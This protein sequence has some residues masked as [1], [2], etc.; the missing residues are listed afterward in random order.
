MV[1]PEPAADGEAQPDVVCLPFAE[2][3]PE[4]L[5]RIRPDIVFSS[6][7]GPGFDCFDLAERLAAAG[8]RGK[9]RAIAP[10]V[11]DPALVRREI[12]DRFPGLD[13]DLVVLAERGEPSGE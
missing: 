12:T 13:F 8:Y 10:T 5:D 9:F 4:A 1:T 11:P 2:V 7:V 3:T 6:L